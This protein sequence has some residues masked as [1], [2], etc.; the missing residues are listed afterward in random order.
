MPLAHS[1]V[2]KESSKY[3]SQEIRSLMLLHGKINDK[4]RSIEN[5]GVKQWVANHAEKHNY[6][7][8]M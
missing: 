6:K 8:Q 7:E 2:P 3:S 1:S 5:C 4:M